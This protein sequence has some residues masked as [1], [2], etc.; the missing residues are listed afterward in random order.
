MRR[1]PRC[2]R[3]RARARAPACVIISATGGNF[4]SRAFLQVQFLRGPW[5][6][7]LYVRCGMICD[8]KTR[9]SEGATRAR[10]R[11]L[12]SG[13]PRCCGVGDGCLGSGAVARYTRIGASYRLLGKCET[14][15]LGGVQVLRK[16]SFA[17]FRP[18]PHSCEQK[19]LYHYSIYGELVS[20]LH[21]PANLRHAYAILERLLK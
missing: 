1:A 2:R 21:T 9:E 19:L 11:L 18:H 8:E 10:G 15:I 13:D 16:H 6:G 14:W 17:I 3:P 20:R 5:H 4:F 12:S 7:V